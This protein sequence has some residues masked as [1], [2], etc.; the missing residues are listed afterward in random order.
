MRGAIPCPWGRF[1]DVLTK[2][3][4]FCCRR[5]DD[6]V[7]YPKRAGGPRTMTRCGAATRTSAERDMDPALETR[8]HLA[9]SLACAGVCASSAGSEGWSTDGPSHQARAGRRLCFDLRHQREH[10]SA[11][12]FGRDRA[13]VGRGGRDGGRHSRESS[14]SCGEAARK[15]IGTS[16]RR[17]VALTGGAA[18]G[19]SA[20]CRAP[21]RGAAVGCVRVNVAHPGAVAPVHTRTHRVGGGCRATPDGTS[22]GGFEP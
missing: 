10:G 19:D 22:Q 21:H 12:P 7:S 2:S 20:R 1:L 3:E 14:R 18:C 11:R 17:G 9:V 16:G 5:V 6:R 4:S 13:F 8:G 15:S